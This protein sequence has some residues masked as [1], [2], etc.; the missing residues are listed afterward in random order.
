MEELPLVLNELDIDINNDE[1]L[2]KTLNTFVV[3]NYRSPL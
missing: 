3:R 1:T 2:V